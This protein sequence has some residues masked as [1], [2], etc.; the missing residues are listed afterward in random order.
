MIGI[1]SIKT[2]LDYGFSFGFRVDEVV[3]DNSPGGKKVTFPEIVGSLD[4]L[5]KI[6]TVIA[7]APQAYKEWQDIDPD[8]ADELKAYFAAKFDVPDDKIEA[9]VEEVW[10]I[11]VRIGNLIALLDADK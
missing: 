11:L 8:E 7:S 2:L 3:A 9:V 10:G 4:L 6:P 1:E 5:F